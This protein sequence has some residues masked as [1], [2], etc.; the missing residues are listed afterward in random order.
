ML[1]GEE[2]KGEGC[3]RLKLTES[4][5]SLLGV[6]TNVS[7]KDGMHTLVRSWAGTIDKCLQR[8][9]NRH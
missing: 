6:Q 2:Q 8:E 9:E 4:T 1:V 3:M 7:L 5:L